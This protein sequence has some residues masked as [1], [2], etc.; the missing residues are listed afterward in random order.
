M[1][2]RHLRYFIAVAEE[3]HFGRAAKRLKISQPPL[4]HQIKQ[5][6]TEM[7]LLLFSRTSQRVNLTIAGE[8]FLKRAYEIIYFIDQAVDEAKRVNRG[9]EGQIT[10]AF[11]GAT[12]FKLLPAILRLHQEQYPNININLKQMTTT[13]QIKAFKKGSIDI[14]LVILPL[15]NSSLNVELLHEEPFVVALPK[16]HHLAQNNEFINIPDL[17]NEHFI[18][19][20]RSSGE[21]YYDSIVSLFYNVDFSPKKTQEAE[22]LPT[23]VSFVA[24]RMGIAILPSSIQFVKN[25]D[26]KYLP[27]KHNLVTYKTGIAWEKTEI[28]P[29]VKSFISFIRDV[30]I[31]E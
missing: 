25:D 10:I 6:E 13:E 11:S 21:G 15:T 24:S 2:L 14:G 8:A 23:I 20:P 18:M 31:P 29:I 3:L 27:L 9:E 22:E 16:T 17:V 30:Y 19:T 7:D 26:I 28:S 5:L 12:T 4:S 1:E